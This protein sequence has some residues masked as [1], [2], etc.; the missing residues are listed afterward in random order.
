MDCNLIYSNQKFRKHFLGYEFPEDSSSISRSSCFRIGA[1]L[2]IKRIA[3]SFGISKMINTILGEKGDSL[4]LDYAYNYVLFTQ[5][6]KIF[7]DSK[8][9]SLLSQMPENT[10]SLFLAKWNENME[11]RKKIYISYDSTNKSS[12]VGGLEIVE[13]GHPPKDK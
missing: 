11:H 12:Q 3:Q 4:L 5:G 8:I 2:V 9:S 6:M 1:Y 7:I 10:F 13:F